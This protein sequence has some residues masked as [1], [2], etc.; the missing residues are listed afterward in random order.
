MNFPTLLDSTD[1]DTRPSES[2]SNQGVSLKWT[3]LF[4][5][6]RLLVDFVH[7]VWIFEQ[8]HLLGRKVRHRCDGEILE[9]VEIFLQTKPQK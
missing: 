8:F 3:H 7:L 2:H 6:E 4:V 1:L 9:S 5:N